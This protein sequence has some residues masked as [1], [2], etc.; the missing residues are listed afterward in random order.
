MVLG[1]GLQFAVG[2]VLAFLVFFFGTLFTNQDFGA[3]WMPIVGW[4][5]TIGIVGFLMFLI[6]RKQKQ[7]KAEY[8]LSTSA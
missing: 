3:I 6:I 5:V 1:G 4:T 2:Y 7:L 8:A